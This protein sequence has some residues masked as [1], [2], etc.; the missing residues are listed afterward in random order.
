MT[1]I[2]IS[3]SIRDLMQADVVLGDSESKYSPPIR[4]FT[5]SDVS[6][7]MLYLGGDEFVH[8]TTERVGTVR[9]HDVRRQLTFAAV[10]RHP[11]IDKNKRERIVSYGR[12]V[13]E[14]EHKYNIWQ[15]WKARGFM[16]EPINWSLT[17]DFNVI[18]NP[19]LFGMPDR[20]FCSQLIVAAYQHG[21][22]PL[23]GQNPNRYSP[24]DLKHVGL[25]FVGTLA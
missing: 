1:S 10:Y 11:K 23:H 21:G 15:V 9:W 7:A 24:E 25:E 13:G 20:Y 19:D 8:A 6:H 4:K 3:I 18:A 16:R 2:S 14:N 17:G 5:S 12:N 22:L